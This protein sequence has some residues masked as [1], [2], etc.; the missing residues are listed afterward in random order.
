MGISGSLL[1]WCGDY[2]SNRKQRVVVDGKCSSWLN[3]TSGVPQASIVGPLFFV[4]FISDLPEVVSQ[5]STVALY[6]DDCKAFRV[7]TCPN[8]QLIFQGDLDGL[9]T[10]S[11]QNR[12]TFNVKKCTLMR[13]TLKKQ[14]LRSSF[15]LN[16]NVLEEVDEFRDLG[17]LTNHHLSWNSHVDAITNKANRI[18]G[19]LRRTCRGW[20]DTETLKVLYCTLVRSQVE[21]GSVEMWNSIPVDIRLS[22][23]LAAFKSGMKKFLMLS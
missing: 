7:V 15:S 5:G 9:C 3:I 2:L 16:G 14:P 1:A 18:L 6:A 10:W 22:P 19:L 11:Q 20:K 4:I 23:S 13:I 21:Y 12:M 17:L 8:D